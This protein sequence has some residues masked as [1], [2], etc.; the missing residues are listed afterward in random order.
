MLSR[1]GNLT[2]VFVCVYSIG[3]RESPRINNQ[4]RQT[5]LT[6]QINDCQR[7]CLCL[8]L[9]LCI[10]VCVSVCVLPLSM[11]LSSELAC[12]ALFVCRSCYLSSCILRMRL[13]KPS[14]EYL[15][16]SEEKEEV[17][18]QLQG[19]HIYFSSLF[20]YF[21]FVFGQLPRQLLRAVQEVART[22]IKLTANASWQLILS[23]AQKYL[24]ERPSVARAVLCCA[25]GKWKWQ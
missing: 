15:Q 20:Q 17:N 13:A 18:R 23:A 2:R 8:P 16:G 4:I 21:F 25:L 6:L 9:S 12:L 10:C 5:S 1:Q 3:Y 22:R 7:V 24:G 14:Q 11:G 19:V